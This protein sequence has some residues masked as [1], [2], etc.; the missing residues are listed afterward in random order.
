MNGRTGTLLIATILMFS[1][2]LQENT[3]NGI[4]LKINDFEITQHE[5]GE[6]LQRYKEE[7]PGDRE[8]RTEMMLLDDLIETGLLYSRIITKDS[9]PDI[10]LNDEFKL[11]L[12]KSIKSK[13]V[14][15]TEKEIRC[16]YDRG[17]ERLLVNY[18][19][20]P[21]GHQDLAG[22]ISAILRNGATIDELKNNIRSDLAS[23]E[24]EINYEE[25][26]P[27]LPGTFIPKLE[28]K[29]FQLDLNDVTVLCT[30]G[31]YHIVELIRRDTLIQGPFEQE[32]SVIRDRLS[33]ACMREKGEILFDPVGL[34]S[35]FKY[36]ERILS[37]VDTGI[38]DLPD[39]ILKEN[40]SKND[41]EKIIARYNNKSYTVEE[42]KE[43][44]KTVPT[45]FYHLFTNRQTR[46]KAI[47]CLIFRDAGI[48]FGGVDYAGYTR[49]KELLMLQDFLCKNMVLD[50]FADEHAID[51]NLERINE[52]LENNMGNHNGLVLDQ[53]IKRLYA[54]GYDK[55][56][57]RM[58][59][60]SEPALPAKTGSADQDGL[61]AWLHPDRYFS[62]EPVYLNLNLIGELEF[63]ET[64]A[65]SDTIIAQRGSW[66][67]KAGDFLA[68]AE[69]YS[70]QTLYGLTGLKNKISL[71]RYIE[72]RSLKGQ[73]DYNKKLVINE[74]ALNEVD[75]HPFIFKKKFRAQDRSVIAVYD[76]VKITLGQFREYIAAL[77]PAEKRIC[78]NILYRKDYLEQLARHD[79]LVNIYRDE[80]KELRNDIRSRYEEIKKFMVVKSWWDRYNVPAGMTLPDYKMDLYF[81]YLMEKMKEKETGKFITEA[82]ERFTV[83]LDKAILEQEFDIDIGQLKNYFS[84]AF[85]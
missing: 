65:L 22:N 70:L 7:Y 30:P 69:G 43:K 14:K 66:I 32:R 21:P 25:N 78:R 58:T 63:P 64:K 73:S 23:M 56:E 5:F 42:L 3:G 27:I 60:V 41:H 55:R 16:A 47:R 76:S 54:E 10:D 24:V 40:S 45:E 49:M 13:Q 11:D 51:V 59:T 71:V 6:L 46:Y 67:Y 85:N 36:S 18:V 50:N 82:K 29:V 15:I 8:D 34:S 72:Q 61:E 75:V 52:L 1:C 33:A 48:K 17:K 20:V 38:Y 31:G 79:Y 19:W 26:K 37:F 35:K 77:T 53:I 9:F 4:L 74:Q 68:E 44:I 39:S 81:R 12:L 28:R 83:L 80:L 62:D 2:S 57:D 84:V